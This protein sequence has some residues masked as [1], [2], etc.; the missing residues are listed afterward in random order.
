MVANDQ[1][2][3]GVLRTDLQAEAAGTHGIER[4]RA[5]TTI[6]GSGH[7][8]SVPGFAAKEQAGFDDARKDHH[9]F[10]VG[11]ELHE[12]VQAF[13]GFKALDRGDRAIDQMIP[14]EGR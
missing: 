14:F 9:G 3:L 10:G 1:D 2:D 5:P 7:Q 13:D 8:Q 4:R 6:C 12:L 11:D